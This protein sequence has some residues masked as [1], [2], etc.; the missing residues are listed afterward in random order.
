MYGNGKH[1]EQSAMEA[2]CQRWSVPIQHEDR[3]TG[4]TSEEYNPLEH[5]GA[6]LGG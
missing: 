2:P 6:I 3:L 4:R 5:D 1:R